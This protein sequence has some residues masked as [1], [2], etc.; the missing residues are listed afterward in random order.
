MEGKLKTWQKWMEGISAFL[1]LGMGIYKGICCEGDRGVLI[2]LL[3]VAILLYVI[4]SIAALF[5]A[6]W[7]MTDKQKEKIKDLTRYQEV[8]TSIFVII[9][10]G[11]SI[12][13]SFFIW[14][15]V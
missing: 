13:M 1:F 2:T 4:I 7:R 9:N 11:L 10:F 6:T 14:A 12:L 8:Y 3:F 5:P 15:I